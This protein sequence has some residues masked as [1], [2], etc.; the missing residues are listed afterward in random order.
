MVD[1]IL[2]LN[3]LIFFPARPISNKENNIITP[4]ICVKMVRK[5]IK[6]RIN[7]SLNFF[8]GST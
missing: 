5:K 6:N 1:P 7:K 2:N 8:I 3:D 4:P